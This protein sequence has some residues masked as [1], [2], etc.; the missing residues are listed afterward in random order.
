MVSDR[1]RPSIRAARPREF[2]DLRNIEL[3]ADQLYESVG[4]GPFT[5]DD[6]ADHFDE[7]ELVL[8]TGEPPVG[9]ICVEFVDGIPHIW[10]LSVHPDHARQGLGRSLVETACAWARTKGFGAITLTTYRDVPWNGPFYESL[11]FVVVHD[12]SP[13]LKAIR[14]HERMMGDDAFGRRVAMRLTL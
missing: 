1:P 5:S 7:A 4:I 13:G 3:E 2:P 9:F 8:V 10:Q 6:A 14:E 11:G 12:L